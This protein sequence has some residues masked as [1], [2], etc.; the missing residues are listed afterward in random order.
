M[1]QTRLLFSKRIVPRGQIHSLR[2][3]SSFEL[4]SRFLNYF[5]KQDHV[6]VKSASLIPQNDKSLLFTNAGMVPFKEYFLKPS[7]A[8]FKSATSV[9]K[10][11]RAGGKHNDL[12]NVGYTP[13][14][15]TFFEM[16]GNF[17]F[18]H[19]T[20]AEAIDYAWKFLLNELKLPIHRL[21][22]TV[23]EGDHEGYELWKKQGLPDDMIVKC[24][25]EDNFWSMG[26]G[27]GPCGPC[28]EIFW[29]TE[30][31]SL[32]DPWLEIWNLVFMEKYRDAEGKL[33]DLPIP[34]ID[35]GMG[36]ERML[37]VLQ[38]KQNNYQVD[39]FK[40]LIDGL[41]DILKARGL[42]SSESVNP[43]AHEKIVADHFRAMCFLIGDGVIPSNVGRGYVLRRIIRRA[44]RS[45]K[46]LG[47]NESFLSDLYP[48][49]LKSFPPDLYPEL[50]SR[51]SSICS[52][53]TNEETSFLATLG[54]GMSLLENVFSQPDLQNAKTI[55]PH[56]AFQLYDT[57]GFPFDLTLI[58]AREKGWTVDIKEWRHLNI[59]PQ[60][61]GYDHSLLHQH[62]KIL[63][64]EPSKKGNEIYLAIDP[65]P[66]YGLGG[67]QV[68]DQGIITLANKSEWQVTDVVQP[69]EG[70]IA[71][72]IAPINK[73]NAKQDLKFLQ[74]GQ[75]VEAKVD[76]QRREGVEIHH[77]ATHLLNAGLRKIL[78]SDDIVQAGS[79]VEPTKLRF[80]FTYGK[81]L[82]PKELSEIENW[83]NDVALRGAKT[84]VKHMQLMDAVNSGAVAAFTEK[85]GETVR[86]IDVPG[87]SKELCGGTHVDDIRK[88]YPFKILNET[89][90]AAG[91]RRIEAVAGTSC[92]K[93]HR[94]TYSPIP[95]ALKLLRAN[96]TKDM[97]GKLEKLLQNTK[98]LQKRIDFMTEKLASAGESV[99]KPIESKIKGKANIDVKIH[100][101]D[102][103]L[104][105][106][107]MQKR[108]NIL[109]QKQPESVHVLLNGNTILVSLN[110]S[111]IKTET[112]NSVLRQLLKHIKGGGGGQK[113]MAQGHLAEPVKS[114]QD[115]VSKILPAF[116]K[117]T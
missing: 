106:S 68:P 2:Q 34:C 26:E 107:F 62:S 114:E 47:I 7:T 3:L 110:G 21:R 92:I 115:I 109:K 9:Q 56:I 29:N 20:K 80:D 4:R 37:T 13:R 8:P 98:D 70:G 113:E 18:G 28:T 102:S 78:H 14:H 90:V 73:E 40:I 116:K 24:G 54:R 33:S 100:L 66:F 11:M 39:Q 111:E 65:C 6:H 63:A 1:N 31:P 46:Q 103:D 96:E 81:P 84:Q 97:V 48:S 112:A 50:S 22:V 108:A 74:E 32:E 88:L 49:L 42:K 85:Y 93:W 10:C 16:L 71:L 83:I 17:S 12:D 25:P 19:Y 69:Y 87:I 51:A 57:Y 101:I 27:E 38:N 55:P 86:V 61:T 64:V 45:A 53:I 52:I 105:A 91:T 60:F 77:T 94:K 117:C 35:T 72:C 89:S 99:N 30:D 44:L 75:L 82:K 67:G 58:I 43:S 76:I 79:T 5:E 95:D 59:K 15:H 41:R 23:L 104:D 36:L